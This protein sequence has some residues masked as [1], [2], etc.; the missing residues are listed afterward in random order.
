MTLEVL[1]HHIEFED[2][3][4]GYQIVAQACGLER[5]VTLMIRCPGI[6]IY[7]PR[8]EAITNLVRKVIRKTYGERPLADAKIKKLT[9]ELGKSSGW[10]R[11]IAFT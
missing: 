10:I 9:I 2:L 11:R 8:T 6:Q 5:T 4:E 7:V 3:S 1:A